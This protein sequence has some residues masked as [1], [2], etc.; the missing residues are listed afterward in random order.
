MTLKDVNFLVGENGTGKT[1]VLSIIRLLSDVQFWLSLEFNTNGVTLGGFDDISSKFNQKKAFSIGLYRDQMGLREKSGTTL[2]AFL[3]KFKEREG[4][5]VLSEFSYLTDE[6]HVTTFI[7]EDQIRYSYQYLPT[8]LEAPINSASFF[9]KWLSDDEKES[10]S[11]SKGT[12]PTKPAEKAY[13]IISKP[14]IPLMLFIPSVIEMQAL[15]EGASQS[16][17]NSP[18]MP[19]LGLNPLPEITSIAEVG[20]LS[21]RP[22]EGYRKGF[23]PLERHIPS[24]LHGYLKQASKSREVIEYLDKFGTNSGLYEGISIKNF[25]SDQS[26]PFSITIKL[27]GISQRISNVGDGLSHSLPIMTEILARPTETW[28]AIQQPERALHPRAQAALG[29]LLFDAYTWQDKKF[30]IETHSDFIIDRFRLKVREYHKKQAN[31]NKKQLNSQVLFFERTE[32][33]NKVHPIEIDDDGEY[34]EEQP[35]NFRKFFILEEMAVLG[36]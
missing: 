14:S 25:G 15:R 10:L 12:S 4:K 35:E 32:K 33:G 11:L 27:N 16:V 30:V 1:S 34:S 20:A 31:P 26:G 29:E 28:F 24:L 23:S 17:E 22:D 21:R 7:T 36:L 13:K 5:P 2:L 8:L 9:Q 19:F 3:M 6:Q 18:K